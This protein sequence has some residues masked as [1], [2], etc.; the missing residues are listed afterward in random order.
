M[1]TEFP[2]NGIF[3]RSGKHTHALHINLKIFSTT[4]HATKTHTYTHTP[5]TPTRT[6]TH[7]HTY[8]HTYTL[9][10]RFISTQ[11]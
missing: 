1:Q 10:Y 2:R 5:H 3:L 8:T 9:A 4:F 7:I 6:Q 11:S